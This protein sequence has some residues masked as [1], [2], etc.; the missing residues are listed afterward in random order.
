VSERPIEPLPLRE[1]AGFRLVEKIGFGGFADVYEAERE[2]ERYALKLFRN[3]LA[4]TIDAERY[5]REIRTLQIDHVNLVRY[6][7]SGHVDVPG[8]ELHWLAMELL[9]GRTLKAEL[10]DSGGALPIARAREVAR[11][12][13]LGLAAL[14]EHGAV[15]RDFKPANVHIGVDGVI[16]LLDFGVVSLL[17]T[18]TITV[19]GR[20]PGTLAYA[21]P[22]QLRN[23]CS[24]SIDL[25]ALGVVLYEMLTGQRPHRGDAAQLYG[26]ILTEDPD[27]PRALNPEVPREL[28]DLVVRL[29]AKEP[30]DRPASALD[31][32]RAL[33]PQ[34]AVAEPAPAMRRYPR[35]A[36]PRIYERVGVRDAASF[37]QA[38]LRGYAP[39]GVVVG[40]TEKNAIAAARR[41]TNGTTMDFIVDP[42]VPRLSFLSFTRTKSL[43]ELAYSPDGVEPFQAGD[44]KSRDEA[45]EFVRKVLRDQDERGAT[46]LV[47]PALAM[48]AADDRLVAVNAKLIDF[49]LAETAVFGKKMIAQVPLAL[50]AITTAEARTDLV[51]RLRRGDPDEYWVMLSPLRPSSDIGEVSTALQFALLL[52]ETGARSIVARAGILRHLFLAFGVGG[53]ELGLGR[54]NGFRFSD[55]E[56]EG[57]PGYTP[58]YFEF[59]SLVS[60]LSREQTRGVLEAG[61]LPETE[62]PC[63][64]CQQASSVEERLELTAEHNAYVIHQERLEL[65]GLAPAL[66]VARLQ[67]RIA[68][69]LAWEAKLRRDGVLTGP[70]LKHLRVWPLVIELVGEE[71]LDD[72]PMR[73]RAVS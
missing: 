12:A 55:W 18:T 8:G 47:A 48:R 46:R 26:G 72:R 54:L 61:V 62:C 59:P 36:E 51:N 40:V 3:E 11:Q 49:A 43:R 5:R 2:G 22:E 27:P 35:D 14:H 70:V 10:K 17:D 25:Y 7:D 15:H 66:R 13:A 44:F 57:G 34:I 56:Q 38:C 1:V 33:Q 6:V 23:E 58:P 63:R 71:L 24:V 67:D 42:L 31:V 53:V 45:K 68:G 30:M 20:V 21:A 65:A 16:R 50:E 29:L 32:V 41:A 4:D 73:R 19:A 52:Q 9:E 64:A 39:H 37:T 60:A 28:E 69:A